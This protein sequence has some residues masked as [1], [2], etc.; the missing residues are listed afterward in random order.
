M[1]MEILKFENSPRPARKKSSSSKIVLGFASVAAVAMLGSTLAASITLNDSGTVEFGQGVATTTA[2]DDSIVLTPISSFTNGDGVT[3]GN[4]NFT[5]FSVSGVE[6]TDCVDKIF[7]VNAYENT[8]GVISGATYTFQWATGGGIP[9]GGTFTLDGSGTSGT[10]T[11]TSSIDL[12]A[13]G[14]NIAKL[15]L[16][17]SN[18]PAT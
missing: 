7:T 16:E 18:A 11:L 15:T 3:P 14:G 1:D 12:S 9:S 8:G 13:V 4:F 17:T 5:S 10:F 6:D 2:C